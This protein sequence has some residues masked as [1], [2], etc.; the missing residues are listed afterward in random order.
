MNSVFM[1][2][3]SVKIKMLMCTCVYIGKHI[4]THAYMHIHTYLST[5]RLWEQAPTR[6]VS[7]PGS[8]VLAFRYR[9]SL[10]EPGLLGEMADSR[11]RA[12][13][14]QDELGLLDHARK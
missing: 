7:V 11:A 5:E 12:G 4:S 1:Y 9:S 10:S 3:I 2:K 13:K 14:M 6:A 8:Q